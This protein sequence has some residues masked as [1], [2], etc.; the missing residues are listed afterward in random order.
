MRLLAGL[1]LLVASQLWLQG[2]PSEAEPVEYPFVAGFDRFYAPEDASDH[3]ADGGLVLLNEMGCVNCHAAPAVWQE[4]LA[5]KP[6]L[7]LNSVGSRLNEDALW[8]FIRSPQH[9]KKGTLMPGMFAGEERDPNIVEALTSYLAT[10]KQAPKKFPAGDVKRGRELYHTVGCVACHDPASLTDYKPAEAPKGVEVEKPSLPSV[11][12]LLADKYDREALAA[13][14]QDPLSIRH[15]GRM[16]ATELTDQE[17]ADL[18][19]Y[20]QSYR[21]PGKISERKMLALPPGNPVV[22]KQQFVMQRCHSCHETGEVM[23]PPTAKSLVQLRLDQ[24]CLSLSKKAGVPDF[25]MS[26]FQRKA[27]TLALEKVIKETPA[28]WTAQEKVHDHLLRMNCYACHEFHDLGG[29][30]E[31]RGQYLTVNNPTVHSLGELGRLPPKLDVA[32]RKL[33]QGWMEK[34]LWGE[35]GGVRDYMTARMP[36]FGKDNTENLIPLLQES[37]RL[38]QP[39]A[40][41]TSGL[42]K[43]HRGE[44]GRVLLGVGKGGLGCVSCH[45][46]KDRASLGVP[47]INLTKTVERLQPGYFKELL[48]DPQVTQ[49]GTLMPPLFM[50]RK[51]ANEEIEQLWTYF[52]EI[53]QSRLP[54]GL[55]QTGDYELKPESKGKP[56]VFRTF[57]EGAGT[58]AVAVGFP[59]GVNVAFDAYESRWALAWQGRFL[60]A[61]TTWEERAMTPAKPLGVKV[62]ALG[63]WMP[64]AKLTSASDSWPEACGVEAGYVFKGQRLDKEGYPTFLYQVGGIE[65]EDLVKPTADGK[66]LQRTVTLRGGGEGWYFRGWKANAA[67]VKILWKDGRAV[68]QETLK[69]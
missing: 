56:M 40:M 59:K 28:L 38:E 34:L 20:L 58:Q 1:T 44:L 7:S 30:E 66:V 61:M 63:Q 23:P 6:K 10:L 18:A 52:K 15:S 27:I 32:G 41:D 35:G 2:H 48:L 16:P 12:M 54:E 60:D 53:D 22:G 33:T 8:L 64:L 14:L 65:I 3:I 49:P 67:P 43:H 62:T 57:L 39:V 25:G 45:G 46:L 36:R 24:G 26:E 51:K 42:L 17:A 31:A 21:E 29:I 13:F 4:R 47:V 19:D 5:A 9:F 69:F 68:L 50:G 11:P 55:L 37:S